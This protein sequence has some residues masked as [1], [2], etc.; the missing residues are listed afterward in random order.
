M[1]EL[2][3]RT[4]TG[5][6][7]IGV[8]IGSVIL[9]NY[10]FAL[11][12]LLFTIVGQY[13]FF[14]LMNNF[15]DTQPLKTYGIIS[16]IFTYSIIVLVA[17]GIL[18]LEFLFVN[19]L[20]VIF[21]F[22]ILLKWKRPNPFGSAAVTI[23]SLLYVVVPFGILNFML[24][25]EMKP[26]TFFP[27]NLIGFF[28]LIWTYDVFAYLIGTIIGQHKLSQNISPKKTW[29]GSIGSGIITLGASYVL[30][31]FIPSFEFHQWFA[32]AL[33]IIIFGTLGDITE[34]MLKRSANVKD[35]GN[36]LPGHGGVL[37][38]FDGV[39]FCAPVVLIYL[40]LIR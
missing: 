1:D 30:S 12:F 34:S 5:I 28:V 29:E 40:T 39:L 20:V 24:N 27:G 38:R 14:R 23:L 35:S 25:P 19:L 36:L 31:R 8:L 26:D 21:P 22:V 3:K 6:V 32:I 16:G 18:Q 37:D 4:V 11:L 2:I 17:T 15:H 13:E 33:I 10:V 7:F 9:N